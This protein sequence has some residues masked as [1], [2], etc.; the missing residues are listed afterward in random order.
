[1]GYKRRRER[2]RSLLTAIS[3]ANIRKTRGI[4]QIPGGRCGVIFEKN[5]LF[6]RKERRSRD[7]RSVLSLILAFSGLR[8]QIKFK[9]DSSGH[10]LGAGNTMV[11]NSVNNPEIPVIKMAPGVSL[12]REI[13]LICDNSLRG[14]PVPVQAG[15]TGLAGQPQDQKGLPGNALQDAGTTTAATGSYCPISFPQTRAQT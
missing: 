13:P 11:N 3:G 10:P 4:C 15:G 7:L 2:P 12:Y 8:G 6:N 14:L 5:R 9:P 1:M